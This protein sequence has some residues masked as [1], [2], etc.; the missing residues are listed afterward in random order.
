MGQES[1]AGVSLTE[2]LNSTTLNEFSVTLEQLLWPSV[3]FSRSVVSDSW[4]ATPWTAACQACLSIAN[5]RS[6]ALE[7]HNI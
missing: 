2:P 4:T 3:Q 7:S 6:L 1:L 5:S